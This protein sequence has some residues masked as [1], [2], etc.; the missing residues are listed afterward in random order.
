MG[1]GTFLLEIVRRLVYIYGYTENDVK[2]RVFGYD[3]RVK[4]INHLQRRGF[5]NTRHKDFLN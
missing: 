4:F 1:K 5:V 3:V 2:S